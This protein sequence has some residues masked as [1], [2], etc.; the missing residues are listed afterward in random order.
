MFEHLAGW[1]SPDRMKTGLTIDTGPR[2]RTEDSHEAVSRSRCVHEETTI[3]IR[4]DGKRIWRGKVPV[5]LDEYHDTFQLGKARLLREGADV[6]FISSG[7]MICALEGRRR[8]KPT[9]SAAPYCSSDEQAFGH[10]GDTCRRGRSWTVGGAREEPLH[11][12]WCG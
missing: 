8:L 5:V 3:S 7:L 2:H 11:H 12:W 1:L 6:L 4:Q 9:G 10:G